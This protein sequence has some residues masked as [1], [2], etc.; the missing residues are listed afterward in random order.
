[1]DGRSLGERLAEEL[2][3]S[4]RDNWLCVRCDLRQT[5][6]RNGGLAGGV[7]GRPVPLAHGRSASLDLPHNGTLMTLGSCVSCDVLA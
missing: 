7:V 3:T 4:V 6:F 1:M 2:R 5:C